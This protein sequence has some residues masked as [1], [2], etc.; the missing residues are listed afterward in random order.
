MTQKVYFYKN[1]ILTFMI[2]TIK[3]LFTGLILCMIFTSCEKEYSLEG[4]ATGGTPGVDSGSAK[5]TLMGAPDACVTPIISGTYKKGTALDASNTVVLSVNVTTIGTYTISTATIN[6]ISFTASGTFTITGS[7]V[8]VLTGTG[9]PT[10]SGTYSY[11]PGYT[12]CSFAIIVSPSTGASAAGTL[13][14]ATA[15][16]AGT[17]TQGIGLSGSNTVSIPVNVTTAGTY[18]INTTAVNGV[19][20][21]GSGTLALGAQTIVLTG[22]GLPASAGPFSFPISLGASNCSFSVTFLPGAP[23]AVGTLDCSTATVSG[24]YTQGTAL[25][26]S[27]TISIPVNVTTA[28]P[29]SITTT[30]TNGVTFSGTG[31]LATG[32]QTVVLTGSGT[33]T[34]S[35]TVSIPIS[36]GASS[37]NVDVTF[38]AGSSDFF[39]C[40][41]DGGPITNFNTSLS[42]S[43]SPGIFSIGGSTA[44]QDLSIDIFDSGGGN[45]GTGTYHNVSLTNTTV[46]TTTQLSVGGTN[47][48]DIDAMGSSNIFTVNITS[49]SATNATGTFSGKLTDLVGGSTKMIS[50]GS[51]SISY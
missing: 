6:G 14:C 20:F 26:A 37:C 40:S 4:G 38:V 48:F 50:N 49:I 28:G 42:G 25:G 44:T 16:P 3:L 29:Y 23:P 13:N 5:F 24:T 1:L 11:I 18:T 46:Y 17:Y 21:S 35:G 30:A 51:F 39:K 10:N 7:Q 8:L 15:T 47:W 31:T 9:T 19:T 36:L 32:A 34:N 2:R 43:L 33:G 22:S 45:I 27:N 12:G 41:I